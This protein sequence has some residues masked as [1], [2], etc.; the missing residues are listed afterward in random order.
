MLRLLLL[1]LVATGAIVAV[2]M[3]V[4]AIVRGVRRRSLAGRERKQAEVVRE[5]HRREAASLDAART[6]LLRVRET[7][8]VARIAAL[9]AEPDIDRLPAEQVAGLLVAAEDVGDTSRA[10]EAE[11]EAQ[12]AESTGPARQGSAT[13]YEAALA[14]AELV[15]AAA[16]RD[17]RTARLAGG[18]PKG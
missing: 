6:S 11:V 5:S 13:A 16:D 1:A 10:V 17:L 7:R 15:A 3:L 14:H 12:T 18:E 8:V 2:V 9:L 4:D